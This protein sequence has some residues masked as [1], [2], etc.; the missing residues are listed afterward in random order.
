MA[1]RSRQP[2]KIAPG[3]F[4]REI[5]RKD[6]G[7]CRV[8]VDFPNKMPFSVKPRSV[9]DLTHKVLSNIKEREKKEKRR[10]YFAFLLG[11]Q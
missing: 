4:W 10:K 2:W 6:W 5:F 7:N 1:Y 9:R 3:A 8:G 11:T